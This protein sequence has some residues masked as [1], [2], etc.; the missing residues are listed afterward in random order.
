M[1]VEVETGEKAKGKKVVIDPENRPQEVG[2]VNV[3]DIRS[4]D[5]FEQLERLDREN[6]DFI[7]SYEDPRLSDDEIERKG[8]TVVVEKGERLNHQGDPVVRQPKEVVINKRIREE[9]F[10]Y[11][12]LK[13]VTKS[14]RDPRVFKQ[15]K[16]PGQR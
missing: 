9:T 8:K 12:A 5:R 1:A 2:R 10:S 15:P 14:E 16:Q 6:P 7:H 3:E 13:D 4:D 11:Q